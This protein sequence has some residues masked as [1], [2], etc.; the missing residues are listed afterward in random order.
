[1]Q[2]LAV[3]LPTE[4][5]RAIAS[6][7]L[8]GPPP[9][10][11]SS[12]FMLSMVCRATRALCSD[13]ELIAEQLIAEQL[14][15]DAYCDPLDELAD[16]LSKL[17]P[18]RRAPPPT[19]IR[20]VVMRMIDFPYLRLEDPWLIASAADTMLISGYEDVAKAIFY[21]C[22]DGGSTDVIVALLLKDTNARTA[23]ERFTHCLGVAINA[24][25]RWR[26]CPIAEQ[27]AV[28][29][30]RGI[31]AKGLA[32]LHRPKHKHVIKGL[33]QWGFERALE[34]VLDHHDAV[35][36]VRVGRDVL[37]D[38]CLYASPGAV[39]LALERYAHSEYLFDGPCNIIL[40]AVK[41]G[42]VPCLLQLLA[43]GETLEDA[44]RYVAARRDYGYKSLVSV[45]ASCG[46]AEMARYLLD[47]VKERPVR[48]D[49]RLEYLDYP[50]SMD[51][52]WRVAIQCRGPSIDE[53]K[54][55]ED[56][57]D[58]HLRCPATRC[59]PRRTDAATAA[60]MLSDIRAALLD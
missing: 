40:L 18:D 22:T 16:R 7:L 53:V 29:V 20:D 32:K 19:L 33:C 54:K 47:D 58:E 44:E 59:Y 23:L 15:V 48:L 10:P 37:E 24:K 12:A 36:D 2:N 49:A 21:R 42:S 11:K 46:H 4:L 34:L 56:E 41:G 45:A 57:L 5:W 13:P 3:H 39:T 26:G 25:K 27:Y 55:L 43:V 60:M 8:T 30:L 17:G 51:M 50:T 38:A 14:I 6:A 9:V 28:D 31:N 52:R 1:M 35:R